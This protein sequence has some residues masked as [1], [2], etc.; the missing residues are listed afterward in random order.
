V[1][2]LAEEHEI[3]LRELFGAGLG[4]FT[5]DHRIPFQ[6]SAR[7]TALPAPFV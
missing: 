3:P 1:H 4:V 2:A 5:I 7:L 6:R